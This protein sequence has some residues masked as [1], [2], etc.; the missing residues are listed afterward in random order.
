MSPNRRIA[1][2]VIATY[3]RSLYALVLGIFTARWALQALGR[4][5]YGLM[6]LVGGLSGFVSFFNNL[7]ASAVGRFYAVKIGAA[8]KEEDLSI[9][10]EECRRWFNTAVAMHTIVPFILIVIGYPCGIWAVKC[11]LTIPPGRVADCIWVWRWTCISCF[12]AMVNVPFQAMYTAKQEIAELTIYGFATV[13]LNALFLYYMIS[14]PDDWLVKFVAWTCALSIASQTII[15]IRAVIKYPECRFRVAYMMCKYRIMEICKYTYARFLPRFATTMATQAKAILVNKYM[16]A[17]YNASMTVGTSLSSHAMTFSS[18]LSNAMW[19]A[20]ANKAGEGDVD[21]VKNLS[22]VVCRI[23]SVLILVFGLPL[24]LEI[25][26]VL[27]IWLV[28]PPPFAAEVCCAIL[29]S[30]VLERMTDGYWMAI[31][32]FGKGVVYYSHRSCLGG[33]VMVVVA[34]V[35]FMAGFGMWSIVI[36]LFSIGVTLVIVRLHAGRKLVAYSTRYWLK[37]VFL[38]ILIV[39]AATCLVGL[40]PRV[41]MEASIW[42]VVVTTIV[43]EAVFLPTAWAFVLTDAERQ[44]LMERIRKSLG[45]DVGRAQGIQQQS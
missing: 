43:C 10:I 7:M 9:G 11:F 35:L 17:D 5:D 38:P 4:T 40:I 21:G 30:T 39:S 32:G 42:R 28:N 6:G 45:K 19:P 37:S 22:F 12:I 16:G 31:L 18:S 8:K 36:G 26:E 2:N 25:A 13:T 14:T 34:W 23:G 3:G 41:Y 20:I 1:L 44:Y 27:D 15:G 29:I 24:M 33:F